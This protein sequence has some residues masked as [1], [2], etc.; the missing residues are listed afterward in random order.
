MNHLKNEKGHQ[1]L[2]IILSLSLLSI[3]LLVFF[4]FFFQAK[5]FTVNNQNTGSASQLSQEILEKVRTST[6]PS[7]LG[8]NNYL[9][10]DQWSLLEDTTITGEYSIKVDNQMYYPK[11]KIKQASTEIIHTTTQNALD[12]LDLIIVEIWVKRNGE[13]LKI[14]ETYGYKVR[15][16]V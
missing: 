13:L 2:E 15:P 1:L 7:G 14:N 5:I 4:G 9:T 8:A 12:K 3:V 11:V 10:I 6:I 16:S